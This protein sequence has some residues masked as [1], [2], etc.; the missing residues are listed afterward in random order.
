MTPAGETASPRHG[1]ENVVSA[2]GIVGLVWAGSFV[3]SWLV[4]GR[5]VY[6]L[7]SLTLGIFLLMLVSLGLMAVRGTTS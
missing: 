2:F 5:V 4:F 7:I 3:I 6:G 1:G